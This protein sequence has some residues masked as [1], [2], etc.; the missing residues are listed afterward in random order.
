MQA[1]LSLAGGILAPASALILLLASLW[2]WGA[3]VERLAGRPA[4]VQH[5][6]WPYT[7]TLGMA[8][9][10]FLG[11][12]LNLLHAARPPLLWAT[13]AVG[14]A[15]CAWSYVQ[16]RIARAGREPGRPR[17]RWLTIDR[18]LAMCVALYG[19]FLIA[20]LMPT[21]AFNP[22]DDFHLYL[23]RP[24]RMLAVGTL[25]GN[26]LDSLG[27]DALGAQSFLQAFLLLVFPLTYLNGFDAVLCQLLGLSLTIEMARTSGAPRLLR[28]LAPLTFLLIDGQ[29]V[30][31]TSL[32]SGA[33]V[34]LALWQSY[35]ELDPERATPRAYLPLALLS[36]ALITLKVTL[37]AF[38]ALCVGLALVAHRYLYRPARGV[39]LAPLILLSSVFLAPWLLL[40][41]ETV[42]GLLAAHRQ[43]TAGPFLPSWLSP[44]HVLAPF[45]PG[46]LFYGGSRGSYLAAMLVAL[47]AGLLALSARH[48]A[49]HAART[50]LLPALL[51]TVVSVP[52]SYW[53]FDIFDFKSGLRYTCPI[54]IAVVPIVA[55]SMGWLRELIPTVTRSLWYGV[56]AGLVLVPCSFWTPAVQHWRTIAQLRTTL[57]FP[58]DRATARAIQEELE[59]PR[60]S[61]VRALQAQ[62]P[63]GATLVAW[64]GSPFQ[65]DFHRQRVW[66]VSD[67]GLASPWLVFPQK[68]EEIFPF[69]SSLGAQY[70]LFQSAGM[71]VAPP[72][73]Y[74]VFQ[75]WN[76]VP[77][78][79]VGARAAC[80]QTALLAPG[81]GADIIYRDGPYVVL[82]LRSSARTTTGP[83]RLRRQAGT[84]GRTS[85]AGTGA[86][87]M[88]K[89]PAPSR[90]GSQEAH[91]HDR[92]VVELRCSGRELLHRG[93][94]RR[95]DAQRV[96]LPSCSQ[97]RDEPVGSEELS[98]LALRI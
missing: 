39:R 23:V 78:R 13:W 77:Y 93:K 24:V 57:S 25:A 82:H 74:R 41:L 84:M 96:T 64:I 97:S 35:C 95:C 7:A 73:V 92:H 60:A 85:P 30:N 32:Y 15:V 6:G 19:L 22:G 87:G 51:A 69:L 43:T 28:I 37:A 88:A 83:S 76:D 20:Q 16:R 17:P 11:G 67:Q 33:L 5:A 91:G 4:S 18:L 36:A 8:A 3:L 21:A 55:S 49:P 29:A 31:I 66:P 81:P 1:A 65:L 63:S 9:C 34:L 61:R 46:P 38:L 54:L 14:A 44:A 62:V 72:G 86:Q 75:T 56:V 42:P 79:K 71:G 90:K 50:R 80:L 27:V 58:I 52:I 40:R 26:P 94:R 53:I 59:A 89:R 12:V 70:V 98:L 10:A 68:P 2:G 47:L 45:R 48:A